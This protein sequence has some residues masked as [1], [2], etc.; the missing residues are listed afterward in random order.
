MNRR[1]TALVIG[2]AA[3][4]DA[5]PIKNPT[6]DAKDV[7]ARLEACGFSVLKSPPFNRYRNRAFAFLC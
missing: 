4:T 7:A 5:G 2:N 3:Y 6:N 1:L